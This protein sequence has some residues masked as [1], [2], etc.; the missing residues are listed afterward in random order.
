MK[1]SV[2]TM[3]VATLLVVALAMTVEAQPGGRGG[4]GGPQGGRGGQF[5]GR[6][7]MMMG[8]G[9]M[10]R[11]GGGLLRIAQN[12]A[13]QKEIDALDDQVKAI[14]KAAEELRGERP[15]M[16]GFRDMSEEDRTK[17]FEKMRKEAE[18]RA[19]KG[20]KALAEILLPHQLD[21][22][23]EIQIQ[24]MGINA[25]VDDDVVAKLKLGSKKAKIE[26]AIQ[27]N[28][29]GMREKMM[30]IFRDGDRENMREKMEKLREES[31]AEVL[32]LLSADEKKAFE[33]MKGEP[34]EMPR[35]QFG[36]G[37]GGRGGPGGDRGN[38]GGDRGGDRGRP[39]RPGGV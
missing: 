26:A 10:G 31:E 39:Q 4:R 33:K 7:G 18:E 15:D 25:L 24:Q 30:A 2:L 29:E 17:F 16:S 19:E 23:K 14:D 6:G 20:D 37:R 12:E 13:V 35:P 27:K 8:G 38:R 3:A 9:M 1:R 28:R 32:A 5:G 36:G 22:V 21:R 34:F 11:G